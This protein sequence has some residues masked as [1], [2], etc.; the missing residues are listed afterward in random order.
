MKTLLFYFSYFVS[1]DL[2]TPHCITNSTSRKK[3]IFEKQL[4]NKYHFQIFGK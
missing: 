1:T 2:Q 3:Y 4:D